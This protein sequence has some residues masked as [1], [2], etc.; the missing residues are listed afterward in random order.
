[1]P[2][3][4]YNLHG[5][6]AA[7]PSD[8]QPHLVTPFV[9]LDGFSGSQIWR[10]ETPRGSI[11]L[12]KWPPEHPEPAQLRYIYD[13]LTAVAKAGFAFCPVPVWTTAGDSFVSHDGH[14]WEIAP[15]MRGQPADLK[16]LDE[17]QTRDRIDAALTALGEFHRAI[18]VGAADNLRRD[19]PPGIVKR[20]A[21]LSALHAGGLD[22][23]S[24]QIAIRREIWLELGDRSANLLD[25]FRAASPAVMESLRQSANL[26]V[27]IRP[28]IRDIHRDHVLF[29][30]NRVS[31]IID[32]GAMQRDNLACDVAR[33]LGSMTGDRANFWEAGV[34]AFQGVHPLSETERRL[35][36]VYD[37]SGVLLSGINWLRWIFVEQRSFENRAAVLTRF[38]EIAAR[39]R[40]LTDRPSPEG[41][42][43]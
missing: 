11:C 42:P 41:C 36:R 37:E 20:L 6:L 26:D 17:V 8:C 21:Q 23:L 16:R 34:A 18:T 43:I 32:F 7:Y 40:H 33:L 25:A 39:L 14:L 13:V 24:R 3:I 10:L 15:W 12:R 2:D 35:V 22:E 9:N 29:E 5:V 31:G 1:M 28:C 19:H 27:E 4:H 38:D 30:G